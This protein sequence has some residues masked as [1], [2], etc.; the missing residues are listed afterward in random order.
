MPT[1]HLT[2]GS[3]VIA[4]VV[5]A[6]AAGQLPAGDNWPRFRGENGDGHS[7]LKGLPTSFSP[8]ELDWNIELPGF[9]HGSPIVWEGTLF[10]TSALGEDNELQGGVVRF[11]HCLEARTGRE[12]WSRI[13][14]TSESHRH[15]KNSW[16]S[17]TPATDG[18]RVYVAFADL[19]NYWLSAYDFEGNL[20]W[21]RNLGPFESQHGMGVS[22]ILYKDLV[23]LPN[24]QDGPSSVMA[25]DRRTG[26]TA[27]S[28]LRSIE[29][30]SYATP[31]VIEHNGGPPQLICASG[32]T[33]ISSLDPDSGRLN[34]S[35]GQFGVPPQT[36]TVSSPVYAGGLIVQSNGGGGKGFYMVA[37][38][39]D[40]SLAPGGNRIRHFRD[41]TL[42]YVPT[43]IV[44]GE[45][46][47]LWGDAG[48][49]HCVEPASGRELWMKRVPGKYSGSPVCID[50]KLY[51]ISEEGDVVVIAAEPEFRELGRS[52]LGDPS[53]STPAVAQGRLYLRTFHR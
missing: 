31:L 10:V 33:G 3:R 47:F 29:R 23:I 37:V 28:T 53:H 26:R 9:G 39:P 50:G 27:W 32:A 41:K 5:F 24:D 8:G 4:V 34:W 45:Y 7:D 43:P 48:V 16:A 35:T 42:P 36:R 21:R 15:V 14:G 44:H 11:L 22:P 46:L 52:S 25:F 2:R 6:L 38:D 18:E 30:A 12:K 13:I 19:D 49:V 40:L 51:I 20:D 17:S 1:R